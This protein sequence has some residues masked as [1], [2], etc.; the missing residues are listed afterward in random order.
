MARAS[1]EAKVVRSENPSDVS[2]GAKSHAN[3]DGLSVRA[4]TQRINNGTAG[5]DGIVPYCHEAVA[6]SIAQT[7]NRDE[8]TCR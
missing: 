3:A 1:S 6:I 5:G 8:K 7:Q 4:L 2:L